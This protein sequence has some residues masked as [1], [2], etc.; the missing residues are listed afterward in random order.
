MNALVI[1]KIRE[2]TLGFVVQLRALENNKFI[3]LVVG[4]HKNE[5]LKLAREEAKKLNLKI[6]SKNFCG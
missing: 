1:T 4:E 5:A 2:T 6:V 3:C